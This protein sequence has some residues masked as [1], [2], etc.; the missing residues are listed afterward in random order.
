MVKGSRRG[1]LGAAIRAGHFEIVSGVLPD[2]GGTDDGPDPH[3][4]LESSL[5]A[6]TIITVQM[7]ANR[8]NWPLE[9]TEVEVDVVS[10]GVE[11]TQITRKISF[12]G[13][14]DAE[15]LKR[16]LQIANKCPIHRLLSS[17]IEIVTTLK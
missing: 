14:L 3:R 6:C 4:L 7:Y 15:Q 16:L 2:Q 8:K 17:K 11:G 5:A 10:E 1:N 9:S 13:S 12:S